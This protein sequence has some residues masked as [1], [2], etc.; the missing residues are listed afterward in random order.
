MSEHK[1]L[2]AVPAL[3]TMPTQTAYCMLSLK[4]DCLS[5]FSFI[6]RASCHDARN[7]LAREAIDSGADRVLWLDSDMVFDDDIMIRLGEDL[8]SMKAWSLVCGIYFKRE[9]PTTPVIY[10]SVD[11]KV[12]VYSNYPK[13]KIFKIAGCGFGAV[14][15]TTDLLRE[16]CDAYH[17]GPFTPLPG[18]SEDLSFCWRAGKIGAW[19]VCDSQIKVG[20]VGQMVFG[21]QMYQINGHNK[22]RTFMDAQERITQMRDSMRHPQA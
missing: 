11:G 17:E 3:D 15:M 21:E 1:V 2:I 12:S 16:V 7:M 18:L 10:D 20:H 5:R 22:P 19:M 9:I 4:R 14:M 6:V 8:D 13:D